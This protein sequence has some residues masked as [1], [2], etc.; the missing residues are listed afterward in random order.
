[1]TKADLESNEHVEYLG[2]NSSLGLD[3][4]S[5]GNFHF[6]CHPF[7]IAE[8]EECESFSAV[9]PISRNI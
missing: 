6:V 5:K 4:K 2:S 7:S 3:Q 1:M 8:K 9:Q